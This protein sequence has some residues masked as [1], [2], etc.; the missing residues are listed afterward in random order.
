M[1]KDDEP[2]HE[3]ERTENTPGSRGDKEYTGMNL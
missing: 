2:R 1:E 3:K